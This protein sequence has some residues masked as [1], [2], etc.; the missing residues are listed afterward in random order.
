MPKEFVLSGYL[1]GEEHQGL[2]DLYDGMVKEHKK[3][4]RPGDVMFVGILRR[5]T[6]KSYDD[7]D[8]PPQVTV[9]IVSAEPLVGDDAET[10]KEMLT[11]SREARLGQ[12]LFGE[13]ETETP[14]AK[15]ARRSRGALS[16]VPTP[17]DG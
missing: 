9:K 8:D 2:G 16:E 3:G 10:A 17:G 14:P 1:P 13:G 11:R 12:S 7:T 5:R 4:K 15:P 6:V